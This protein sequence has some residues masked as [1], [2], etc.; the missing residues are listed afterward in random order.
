MS[1]VAMTQ[2]RDEDTVRSGRRASSVHDRERQEGAS[3]PGDCKRERSRR[4]RAQEGLLY[5][6]EAREEGSGRRMGTGSRRE[7]EAQRPAAAA[8]RK[9]AGWTS[10]G[11]QGQAWPCPSGGPWCLQGRRPRARTPEAPGSRSAL[12]AVLPRRL[13][14]I[15]GNASPEEPLDTRCTSRGHP[16]WQIPILR[17]TSRGQ[18]HSQTV[19]ST[20]PSYKNDHLSS[21]VTETGR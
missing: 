14:G 17:S 8:G 4:T 5:K 1:S 6:C 7:Q 15:R 19:D 20:A 10:P 11:H 21:T 18:S 3:S 9:G 12:E 2:G 13:D 16:R